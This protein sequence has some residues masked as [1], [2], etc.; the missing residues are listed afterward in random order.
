MWSQLSRV[1]SQFSYTVLGRCIYDVRTE[2][3]GGGIP[4]EEI[5]GD[6]VGGGQVNLDIIT[7]ADSLSLPNLM[8]IK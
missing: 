8:Q 7:F 3:R 1:S 6:K 2:S 4:K 5:K